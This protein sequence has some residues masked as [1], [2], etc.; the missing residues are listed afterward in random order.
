MCPSCKQPAQGNFCSACGARLPRIAHATTAN[1]PPMRIAPLA[2]IECQVCHRP[3]SG[4][5]IA[6]DGKRCRRCAGEQQFRNVSIPAV[7]TSGIMGGRKGPERH[8]A[9]VKGRLATPLPAPE[10][11]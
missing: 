11:K 5:E 9:G 7:P 3:F 2:R 10:E 1:T 8:Q 6:S 4:T